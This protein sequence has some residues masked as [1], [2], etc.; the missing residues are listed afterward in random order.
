[1]LERPRRILPALDSL[2]EDRQPA[3]G[4]ELGEAVPVERGVDEREHLLDADRALGADRGRNRGGVDALRDLES[5]PQVTLAPAR[6]RRVNGER[7]RLEARLDR[8]GDQR[9]GDAAVAKAVE[10]QPSRRRRGLRGQLAR[11]RGGDRRQA[12]DRP[13]GRR[14]PRHRHLA[15]GVDEALKGDRRDQQ[16][17]RDLAA[18][19]GRRRAGAGD[20]DQDLGPQLPAAERGDVLAQGAL[21]TRA[22]CEIAVHARVEALGR[23]ALVVGDVDR[24][25]HG[26]TIWSR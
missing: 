11:A 24:L 13:G 21:V 4:G 10:L 23:E 15:V 17:H 2:D 8:L 9:P 20:V 19:H 26:A 22:A 3:L 5:G 25:G 16:R 6:A 14:G 12:H 18:E 1:M 7:D